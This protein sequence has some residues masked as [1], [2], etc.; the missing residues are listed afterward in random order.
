[1]PVCSKCAD[2]RKSIA[3]TPVISGAG[4]YPTTL[5]LAYM[6][7][8]EYYVDISVEC[9]HEIKE[10]DKADIKIK[11]MTDFLDCRKWQMGTKTSHNGNNDVKSI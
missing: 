1:M 7:N 9:I 4:S 6:V 10:V 3:N 8:L 2:L 5:E 11:E